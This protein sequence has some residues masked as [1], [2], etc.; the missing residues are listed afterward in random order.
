MTATRFDVDLWCV[1]LAV[2]DDAHAACAA[3]LGPDERARASRF[4]F[5][6]DARRWTVARAGLR[7]VLSHYVAAPPGALRF[8]DAGNGK[9]CLA[10][11]PAAP[12]FNLS[13]AGDLAVVAVTD[14]VPIG[15][16]IEPERV[17]PDADALVRRCFGP[18]GQAA[19]ASLPAC[20]RPA[21]FLRGWTRK[22]AVVKATGAGIAARLDAFDVSLADDVPPRFLCPPPSTRPGWAWHVVHFEPAPGYVGALAACAPSA[23]RVVE[24]GFL[25]GEGA[26]GRARRERSA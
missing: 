12:A 20:A 13:H 2:D 10:D 8:A 24:R 9:P 18:A 5:A 19:Y 23:P 14:D 17:L 22:E 16:D 25:P 26:L 11:S 3:L 7:T 4:R 6:R 1:R 21:A 15:V